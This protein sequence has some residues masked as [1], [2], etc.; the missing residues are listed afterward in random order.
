LKQELLGAPLMTFKDVPTGIKNST[1]R[2]V[3]GQY[4]SINLENILLGLFN[5]FSKPK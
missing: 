5:C 1:L 4:A 3:G 2:H